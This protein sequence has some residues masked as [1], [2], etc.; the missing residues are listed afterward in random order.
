MRVTVGG[1][2]DRLEPWVLVWFLTV[3]L[4]VVP[5]FMP[6]TW[7]LLAYFRVQYGLDLWPLALVGAFGATAGRGLLALASQIVGERIV[8]TRWRENIHALAATIE[9]RPAFSL[10]MFGLLTLGPV[11]SNHLFIAAGLARAS[12]PPLLAVFA[13]TRFI[14]Y[15]LWVTAAA[16]AAQSLSQLLGPRLGGGLAVAIQI[17]GFLFLILI[18]Q[19]DWSTHVRRWQR[20]G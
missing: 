3:L 18:M 4:N 13:V 17:A 20:R 14:S 19:I 12:L 10:S 11:P 9:D 2:M 6:P 5:A 7:A 15:V 8:P 1:A 16:T